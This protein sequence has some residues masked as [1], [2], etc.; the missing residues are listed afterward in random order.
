MTWNK[1]YLSIE[2]SFLF[3]SPVI[4]VHLKHCLVTSPSLKLWSHSIIAPWTPHLFLHW[5]NKKERHIWRKLAVCGATQWLMHTLMSICCQFQ[6]R[7][8]LGWR[9]A[10]GKRNRELLGFWWGPSLWVPWISA[11]NWSWEILQIAQKTLDMW[12]RTRWKTSG[13]RMKL[14]AER[15]SQ[16][17]IKIEEKEK[18]QETV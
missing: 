13:W 17:I 8:M 4:Y 3:Q 6:T 15:N 10:E 7:C 5:W 18:K 14:T 16:D 9:T 11:A 1:N 2:I 12:D